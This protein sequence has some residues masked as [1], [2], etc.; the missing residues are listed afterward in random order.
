LWWQD[1]PQYLRPQA[2]RDH[3]N[4]IINKV[5]NGNPPATLE[6]S[7]PIE[8]GM[9]MNKD[10]LTEFLKAFRIGEE[11]DMPPSGFSASPTMARQFCEDENPNLAKVVVRLSPNHDK[12]IHGLAL[13]ALEPSTD[14]LG[15][16]LHADLMDTRKN[17]ENEQEIIRPTGPKSRCTGVRKVIAETDREDNRYAPT[18]CLYIIDLEEAGYP[19]DIGPVTEVE[20]M[21]HQPVNKVFIEKM[22][23]PLRQNNKR[24][25]LLK[26][27]VHSLKHE[28]LRRDSK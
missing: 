4:S 22:N 7:H 23:T 13:Y 26:N 15:P 28:I 25:P 12:K 11:V 18:M 1:L 8:R 20:E 9:T 17:F 5:C 14:L 27:I 3:I 2:E 21:G 16:D 6:L 19:Q 10:Q 24:T